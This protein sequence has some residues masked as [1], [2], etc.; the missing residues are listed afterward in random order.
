MIL[1]IAT[2]GGRNRG[3]SQKAQMDIEIIRTE[4][5]V[6]A[7]T[8]PSAVTSITESG[9][10]SVMASK[11]SA[12]LE[13][14]ASQ[15]VGTQEEGLRHGSQG[16]RLIRQL[17]RDLIN[18]IY[19]PSTRQTNLVHSGRERSANPSSNS[20]ISPAIEGQ[21]CECHPRRSANST[22]AVSLRSRVT[23]LA[24]QA[25]SQVV[26]EPKTD[27]DSHSGFHQRTAQ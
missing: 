15:L 26:M 10:S 19:E 23:F 7:E 12:M 11:R 21:A 13:T 1:L 3:L 4:D 6:D 20:S 18:G 8:N 17:L 25:A 24:I 27:S 16:H 9:P 2:G 14:S 5:R 22:R